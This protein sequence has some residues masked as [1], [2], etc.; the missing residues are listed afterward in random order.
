MNKTIPFFTTSKK[1]LGHSDIFTLINKHKAHYTKYN[2]NFDYYIGKHRILN[3]VQKDASKP[4]NKVVVTL[5]H[6]TTELRVGYFSGEPVSVFNQ[7]E[8]YNQLINDVL[9]YNDFQQLNSELDR[10]SAIYGHACM[11]IYI[12]EN[13]Q[14][15]LVAEDPQNCFVVYDNSL[16]HDEL[17]AIRYFEWIDDTTNENMYDITVYEK[18]EIK[19]Y[20]GPETSLRLIKTEPNYFKDIPVVEFME[21]KYRKGC[22]EDQIS[23]V[24][25]IENTMSNSQ[26]EIDY[27]ANEYLLLKNLSGTT[28]D[29]L[30]DMKNNRVFKVDGDGD[31]QFL[32]KNTNDSYVENTLNRLFNNHH[33]CT[34]RP[35]ITDQNFAGTA[36]GVSLKYKLFGLE[37]SLSAKESLWRK[38]LMRVLE[39]ITN[40]INLKSNAVYDY[41]T[42]RLTFVRALPT[43]L[44]ESADIVSKLSGTVSQRT[45]LSQ[46]E[47]IENVDEE[48]EQ[49]QKEKDDYNNEL[50]IYSGHNDED[51][52]Y[53]QQDAEE[54]NTINEEKTTKNM[55]SYN[56]GE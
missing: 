56:R 5:P 48:M 33:K 26:N 32:S 28:S 8:T 49:I 11:I 4:N 51:L 12:D 1:K 54:K 13:S 52:F 7:D 24:D 34:Q 15:R 36:S 2:T 10:L 20:Y 47:F 37:K 9:E 53:I 17:A 50:N 23:I 31:A 25:A 45:L 40:V 29:D 30:K 38:S 27:F 22:Y 16:S 46:L 14:I 19:Y 18:D 6:L 21:N 55:T 41:K 39:I 35:D 3:R 44:T 42:T 43:N